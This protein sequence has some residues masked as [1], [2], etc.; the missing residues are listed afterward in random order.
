MERAGAHARRLH[1]STDSICGTKGG[2]GEVL[3]DEMLLGD[4]YAR[5][6]FQ[7]LEDLC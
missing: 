6:L 2:N 5:R 1:P 4:V 7:F 3:R